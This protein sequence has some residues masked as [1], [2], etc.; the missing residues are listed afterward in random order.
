MHDYVTWSTYELALKY[1]M[2][3]SINPTILLRSLPI[4]RRDGALKSKFI[5]RSE[6]CIMGLPNIIMINNSENCESHSK[7]FDQI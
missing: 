3:I 2:F 6:I 7:P 1:V 4:Q 5:S